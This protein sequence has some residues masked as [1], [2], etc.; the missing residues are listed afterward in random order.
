MKQMGHENLP[1]EK[2]KEKKGIVI[3]FGTLQWLAAA[4]LVLALGLALW[5]YQK[6]SSSKEVMVIKV[7]AGLNLLT[8]YQTLQRLQV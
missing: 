8:V 3:S 7:P 6:N 5:K 2:V 4:C 1:Q